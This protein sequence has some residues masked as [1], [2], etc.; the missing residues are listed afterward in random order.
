MTELKLNDTSYAVLG[1]IALFDQVTPYDLKVFAALSVG[2]FWPLHQA[3]LYG[4]PERL[5]KAGY[6][7]EER[8]KTG[9]RRR[10]YSITGD[11]RRALEEWLA[12]P[13]S[14]IS[15]LRDPGLLRLFM[16]ADQAALGAAQAAVHRKRLEQYRQIAELDLPTGQRQELE[17][18]IRHTEVWIEFWD[19]VA[20]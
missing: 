6:V 18:G 11:G 13:T 20:R 4:E 16:G 3:Q 19:G 7:T 15:E 2:N 14:Q 5:A 17:A 10:L 8:E 9:R 12:E 1:M